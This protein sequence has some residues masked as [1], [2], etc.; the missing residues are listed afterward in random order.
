MRLGSAN[1]YD[2][3]L[4]NL[5]TRQSNLAS[6]QD[7]LTSGKSISRP[8]DDPLGAAQAE[9]D[10]TRLTRVS[11]DQRA[12]G[13]QSG[14]MTLAESTLGDASSL[15]QNFRELIVSAGNAIL[16]PADRTSIAQQ[17]GSLRDQLLTLSNRTD[18]N[19][20]ALFSGLGSTSTP[21][22]EATPGGAVSFTGIAGQ[23]PST[24]HN[25]PGTM[26]GQA[27]WMDVPSGNGTF[28]V[29]QT[30]LSGSTLTVDAGSVSNPA[31]V[32][33][34]NYNITFAVASGV[35]TYGIVDTTPP[36]SNI[37][38][39]NPYTPGQTISFDGQS[40]VASGTPLNG[41][42]IAT[43]PS[44]KISVFKVLDDAISSVKSTTPAMIV[45]QG[46]GLSQLDA[47]MNKILAARGQAGDWLNRADSITSAQ[48]GRT[49][50]LTADMSRAQDLD[51][52]QGLSDFQKMQTG[53]Q[54]A[55]QSYAQVQKLS[56]FNFIN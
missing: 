25:I 42:V 28:N 10:L 26:N 1:T 13:V 53:Y 32:T 12:L 47:G 20:I 52:V 56:L 55:L 19:G 9:R 23:S 15:M 38:S 24:D 46:L 35:T 14:T 37:S 3:V 18:S 39:S 27:I 31:L 40:F 33:G 36:G 16:T 44:T 30:P 41:D 22:T 50:Q 45:S 51:M 29:T 6:Q 5:Y 34:H 7:K 43:S 54:V 21:F 8:S 2:K 49:L 11:S 48:Q 17:M 4:Q